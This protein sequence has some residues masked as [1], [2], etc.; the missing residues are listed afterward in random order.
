MK[1]LRTLGFTAIVTLLTTIVIAPSFVETPLFVSLILCALAGFALAQFFSHGSGEEQVELVS[2]IFLS[3]ATLNTLLGTL[4][5]M[6]G[7]GKH[8][9]LVELA[10]LFL[11]LFL[12]LVAF[13]Q[14]A[15]HR[16]PLRQLLLNALAIALLY[17]VSTGIVLLI[18]P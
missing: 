9:V 14:L 13:G 7:I 5:N 6:L 12:P 3:L 1:L 4:T 17:L 18:T 16:L 10:I 15:K 11:G 2:I 8:N